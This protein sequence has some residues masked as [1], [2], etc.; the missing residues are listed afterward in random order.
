M[1][2]EHAHP[3]QGAWWPFTAAPGHAHPNI[4]GLGTHDND[5]VP[6][7][8]PGKAGSITELY[9]KKHVNQGFVGK[10]EGWGG[11]TRR[12]C[13]RARCP[14]IGGVRLNTG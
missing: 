8:R 12:G 14:K 5:D 6:S 9:R 1:K 3:V 11:H 4:I 7:Y 13:R 10:G 2:N